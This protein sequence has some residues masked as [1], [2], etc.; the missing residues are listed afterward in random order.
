MTGGAV[1]ECPSIFK[2]IIFYICEL[3]S[4]ARS[5]KVREYR[6][7]FGIESVPVR[8]IGIYLIYTFLKLKTFKL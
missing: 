3:T 1:N 8:Y 5:Q 6:S 7:V 4:E 2:L